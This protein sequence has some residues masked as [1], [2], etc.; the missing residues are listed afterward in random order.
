MICHISLIHN[1]CHNDHNDDI[2]HNHN[3]SQNDHKDNIGH[4]DHDDD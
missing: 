4:N 2:G 3:I 1:I